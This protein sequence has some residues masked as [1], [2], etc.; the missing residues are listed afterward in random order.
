V[1]IGPAPPDPAQ[2]G[3]PIAIFLSG[4]IGGKTTLGR[5]LAEALGAGHVEGDDHHQPPRPWYATALSTCRGTLAEALARLEFSPA[6]VISYPLRCREWLYYRRKL[7]DRGV[8]TLFV[9]LAADYEEIVSRGRGRRFSPS[10]EPGSGGD[11][12]RL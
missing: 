2:A 5:A 8:R 11:R 7:A 1:A 3:A 9:T 12:R 10:S 6:V 4:K